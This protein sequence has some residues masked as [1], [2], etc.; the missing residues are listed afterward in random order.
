[1][2][3]TES[4]GVRKRAV[5]VGILA[6]GTTSR[7]RA[8]CLREL[9][10]D[11]DWTWMDTDAPMRA[12]ARVWR[13]L[14]FRLAAGR[15][16]AGINGL[17]TSRMRGGEFELGWVDKGVFL[18]PKTVGELRR[19]CRQLVHFTPDT[20]YHTN[21]SRH[22]D[23][24]LGFY[25]LLVTTKSFELAEY[26]RRVADERV[27]LA[28]QGYDNKLHFPRD[29]GAVRRREVGF[30]GLSEPERAQCVTEL[31]RAGVAVRLAGCGWGR[32]VREWA[33]NPLLQFEGEEL[34]GEAYADLLSRC[35]V[36]LGLLSKQFPELHTTRT[37][38]IPA[39]GAILATERT[40]DTGRFFEPD[41]VLFFENNTSLAAQLKE[42]FDTATEAELGRLAAAGQ[43][44][45]RRDGR[46]NA[47]I[48]AAVLKHP[49]LNCR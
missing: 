21:R 16:V 27:M 14:A 30:V 6:D 45:V 1:M 42:L 35:W 46:D 49:R 34:F 22:F 39:C 18:Y 25:D 11:W 47:S 7:L 26:G 32:L 10:P 43:E 17:V 15:V 20:S 19:R 12:S 40:A 41:E 2:N 29:P 5:Y 38:E 33:G 48:L 3:E 44:R 13:T 9:T 28:T 23:R 36:G 8:E 31:L 4:T 24:S 37:F